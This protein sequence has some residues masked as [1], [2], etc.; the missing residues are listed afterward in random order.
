MIVHAG[1]GG[2]EG[3]G[4]GVSEGMPE[5]EG[6]TGVVVTSGSEGEKKSLTRD[7]RERLEMR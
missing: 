3:V 7:Q 6:R 2:A 4:V 1:P 5:M